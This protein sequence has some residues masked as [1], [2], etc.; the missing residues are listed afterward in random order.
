MTQ[1]QTRYH[2]YH[3]K[4]ETISSAEIAAIYTGD[5]KTWAETEERLCSHGWKPGTNWYG[6][7]ASTASAAILDA[8]NLGF[9]DNHN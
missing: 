6:S 2:V 3:L 1:I 7:L 8:L 5:C 9:L 4:K